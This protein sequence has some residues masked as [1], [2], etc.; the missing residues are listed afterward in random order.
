MATLGIALAAMSTISIQWWFRSQARRSNFR[1]RHTS[2]RIATF[3]EAL[4]SFSWA[5]AAGPCRARHLGRRR[6]R[7]HRAAHPRHGAGGQPA[8]GR[9]LNR[10][11]DMGKVIVS[12]FI[13]LDGYS[14]APNRELVPPPPTPDTFK[15]FIDVNMARNGI[16]IYG[17]VTYEMMINFWTS[18]AAPPEQAKQLAETRKVV[19]S[20]TL[21]KADWGRV[22]IARGD[23]L[24][25]D[26]AAM[27]RETDRDLT[28]LGSP[29]LAN[30]FLRAGLVDA[31]NLLVNPI[32]L[33]GGTPLF[34]G[35]YERTK[36]KLAGTQALDNGSVLMNYDRA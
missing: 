6:K 22:S 35:G 21:Q 7:D 3:G 23:D 20:K 31:F 33:G 18:A 16:F 26:V 25:A 14:E 12:Q 4:V 30:A 17:R 8:Q 36:W 32:L 28:I 9:K 34:Q 24:A 13:S 15:Y 19:F 1:R 11:K 10:D 5:T 29:T 27:R 2:S